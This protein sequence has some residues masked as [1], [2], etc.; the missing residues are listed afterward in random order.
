MYCKLKHQVKWRRDT[1]NKQIHKSRKGEYHY[2]I[3][4]FR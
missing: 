4:L 1:F 3:W 2:E